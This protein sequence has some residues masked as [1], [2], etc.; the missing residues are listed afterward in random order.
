MALQKR[1]GHGATLSQGATAIGQLRNITLPAF[2]RDE[3]DTT[4]LDSTVGETLPADPENVGEVSFEMLWTSGDSAH[5]LLDTDFAA[6]TVSSYSIS[7]PLS[8]PR[9]ATFSAWVKS[10]TPA[11]LDSK[12]PIMRTVVLKLTTIIS[13]A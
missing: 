5:E 3:V 4:T 13:W 8:T 10:M 1:I 6:R 11:P 2:S 9:V 7:V 12:S